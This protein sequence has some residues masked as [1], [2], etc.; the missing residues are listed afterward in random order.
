VRPGEELR[1]GLTVRNLAKTAARRERISILLSQNRRLERGDLLVGTV[2]SPRLKGGRARS[3]KKGITVPASWRP[4]RV[5]VLACPSAV[6]SAA[7]RQRRRCSAGRRPV[8]VLVQAGLNSGLP[9]LS[10]VEAPVIPVVPETLDTSEAKKSEGGTVTLDDGTRLFTHG[11]DGRIPEESLD[12]AAL[13][14]LKQLA[15]CRSVAAGVP[16]LRYCPDASAG[17]SGTSGAFEYPCRVEYDL[18]LLDKLDTPPQGARRSSTTR[19]L[20]PECIVTICTPETELIMATYGTIS[21]AAAQAIARNVQTVSRQPDCTGYPA[22]HVIYAYPRNGAN[23]SAAR[24]PA[25]RNLV[26]QMNGRLLRD[27]EAS[28][29]GF[30]SAAYR[31]ICASFGEVRVD[32]VRLANTD[33]VMND[34]NENP[35]LFRSVVNDVRNAG[36]TN[37]EAKYLVFADVAPIEAFCGRGQVQ[38]DGSFGGSNRNNDSSADYAVVYN[39]AGDNEQGGVSNCFS[40]TVAQH[41]SAHNM[42]AVQ[43]G[44]AANPP[45]PFST[46]EYHCNAQPFTDI[47]CYDDDSARSEDASVR[48]AAPHLPYPYRFDCEFDTYF[49]ASNAPSGYLANHWNLGAT[50]NRFLNFR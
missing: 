17:V 13:P 32:V 23:L 21:F 47:M 28:S 45:A 38:L 24:V 33:A 1:L 43:P 39:G 9:P 19:R 41:E 48:C 11:A 46:A 44:D 31:T 34:P 18:A 3:L 27:S 14:A 42:G 36:Y 15:D 50:Y 22:T 49:S 10:A 25:I 12:L 37:G 5:F 20:D 30:R 26:S 40:S 8:D 2:V 4:G 29:R 35:Q 6:R 16:C 7:S